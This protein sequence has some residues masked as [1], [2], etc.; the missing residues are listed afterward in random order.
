VVYILLY[1]TWPA[2]DIDTVGMFLSKIGASP[3]WAINH[4]YGV[5]N[6]VLSTAAS[7]NYSMGKTLASQNVAPLIQDKI[8]RG[9]FPKDTNGIYLVL[10]SR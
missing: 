1:G 10:S 5:S 4:G 9:I 8:Q 6:V 2:S 3:W 7:D